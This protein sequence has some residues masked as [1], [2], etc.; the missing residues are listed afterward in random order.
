MITQRN[1]ITYSEM[2]TVF[3]KINDATFL[4]ILITV[5]DVKN[6]IGDLDS[7]WFMSGG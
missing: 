2:I 4:S 7:V 3:L 6:A 5:F 1:Y